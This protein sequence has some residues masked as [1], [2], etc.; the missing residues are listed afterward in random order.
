MELIKRLQELC[1]SNRG[2]KRTLRP[3]GI[4]SNEEF[5]KP[6]AETVAEKAI[7]IV[8]NWLV[9]NATPGYEITLRIPDSGEG[10]VYVAQLV[11]KGRTIYITNIRKAPELIGKLS[12]CWDESTNYNTLTMKK[13]CI[14]AN[15]LT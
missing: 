1:S 4:D 10:Q 3:Y 14:A 2:G 8:I 11:T 5:I 9:N 7:C 15:M 12:H 13:S 6:L